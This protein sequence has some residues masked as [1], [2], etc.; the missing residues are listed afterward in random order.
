M[1]NPQYRAGN[2]Y[3]RRVA[4][5]L[6]RDGYLVW[7][8]R[9]SK[10]VADLIAVKH[11]EVVLVQVKASVDATVT[12]DGWNGLYEKAVEIMAVPLVADRDGRRIR[13]RRVTG[14]H[15]KG[16]RVWPSEPW[17]ADVVAS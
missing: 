2:H 16:S 9:G 13:Y 12:H 1:P 6:R 4:N 3:E 8:T 17:T 10:G 5:D 15:R 11:G 14:L 7:Q